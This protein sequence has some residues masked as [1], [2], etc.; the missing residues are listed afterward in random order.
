VCR[1]ESQTWWLTLPLLDLTLA[2]LAAPADGGPL[3]SHVILLCS[4]LSKMVA[5]LTT[6]PHEVVR[7][8]LQIQRT[9]SSS[10]PRSTASSSASVASTST[11]SPPPSSSSSSSSAPSSSSHPPIAGSSRTP[12]TPALLYQAPAVESATQASERPAHV[13]VGGALGVRQGVSSYK[14]FGAT[15]RKIYRE[16]GWKGFYR[17]LSINLV[18]TVPSSAATMLT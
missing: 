17:G 14:G 8:R 7:T 10:P 2:R 16:G 4:G 5:S 1:A 12:V 11:P 15:V 18:R 9:S 6:Y 3:S 13:R